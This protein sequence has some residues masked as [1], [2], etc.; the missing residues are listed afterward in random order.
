MADERITPPSTRVLPV[1]EWLT[2]I[3]T[4]DRAGEFLQAYDLAAR[5]LESHSDDVALRYRAVLALARSG[6]T[7]RAQQLFQRFGLSDVAEEDVSALGARLAKDYARAGEGADRAVRASVAAALYEDTFHR[8]QGFYPG[9]NAATM[10]LL[11]GDAPKAAALARLVQQRC[12]ASAPASDV[13]AYYVNASLA[14][15][16]LILGDAAAARGALETA[17]A[18]G[19]SHRAALA[20]TRRQLRLVCALTG[21]D[22]SVLEPL[23][24]PGVVH[25]SGHMIGRLVPQFEGLV[26]RR[27]ADYLDGAGVGFAYGALA[28]GADILFAEAL[29]K[30]GAELHVVLP[31]DEARFVEMSVARAGRDWVRR[32][33]LCR[34]A[35][36]S[37]TLASDD[38]VSTDDS[39]LTYASSVAMGLAI[40]RARQLD[41]HV[42]QVVVWDG[43]PR[44]GEPTGTEADMAIWRRSGLTTHIIQC[45]PGP[46]AAKAPA[47]RDTA[48]L[49]STRAFLFGD[50]KGF[51][52]LREDQLPVFA[53]G[54]MRPLAGVLDGLSDA[55]LARNTW[56]DGVFL[57]FRDA[58][59]AA[60]CAVAMQEKMAELEPTAL[61][62]PPELGLRMGGHAGPVFE[63]V[64]QFLKQPAFLGSHITRTARI[65]PITPE[66][67]VYVTEQFAALVAL[68]PGTG[69][70]CEYVGHMPMAKGYGAT[71]MYVLKRDVW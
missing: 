33:Q 9:I 19:G 36:R 28:S 60:L 2:Q 57:V 26:A 68:V 34:D 7:T 30:R 54:I 51:S 69:L 1:A 62:L 12:Q 29:L 13:E 42:E 44:P 5:G 43:Q 3:E 35:A 10:W 49:R 64:D 56:G 53:D 67:E 48:M 52:K 18:R 14:E 37:V 20:T 45:P 17:V 70:R 32:F 21:V 38:I 16:A 23:T 58:Q 25:Y 40:T 66:G 11:A 65:E 55:C 50:V 41:T 63:V 39:G 46:S 61:G 27:V 8:T 59:S 6:A 31:C 47:P 4:A 15:A 22:V 24:L 71:R